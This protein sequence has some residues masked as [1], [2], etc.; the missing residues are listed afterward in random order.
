MFPPRGKM[1]HGFRQTVPGTG[2]E[3]QI[4]NTLCPWGAA[5]LSRTQNR[6]AGR[7]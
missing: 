7:R 5:W 6:H 3:Q 1:Q 2:G 4:T